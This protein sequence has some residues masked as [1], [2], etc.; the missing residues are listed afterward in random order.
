MNLMVKLQAIETRVAMLEAAVREL[1]AQLDRDREMPVSI[2]RFSDMPLS[3]EARVIEGPVQ[4]FEAPWPPKQKKG[5]KR[6][7]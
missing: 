4:V 1:I 7:N 6:G 5:R 3:P 2:G